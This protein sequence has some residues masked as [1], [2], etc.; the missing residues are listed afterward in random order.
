MKRER[1]QLT[2]RRKKR[3]SVKRLLTIT[4]I[5]LFLGCSNNDSLNKNSLNKDSLVK[6]R[7]LPPPPESLKYIIRYNGMDIILKTKSEQK[8][9]LDSLNIKDTILRRFQ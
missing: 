2:A 9:F 4:F 8:R 3:K 1:H 5:L 7:T 6:E